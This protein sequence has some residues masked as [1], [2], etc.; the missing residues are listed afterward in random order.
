MVKGAQPTHTLSLRAHKVSSLA[1]E[2]ADD[3][4][5]AD[6]HGELEAGDGNAMDED[7]ALP[8]CIAPKRD[9]IVTLTPA[10]DR[11]HSAA[12]TQRNRAQLEPSAH[13]AVASTAPGTATGMHRTSKRMLH[14]ASPRC[15]RRPLLI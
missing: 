2:A 12:P 6:V 9:P 1:I 8:Q 14:G 5:D 4:M 7:A 15:D 3:M 10:S 13:D 11:S